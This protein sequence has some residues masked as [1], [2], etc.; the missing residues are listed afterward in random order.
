MKTIL[1]MAISK[2]GYIAGPDD[3]TPWSDAEW[4]QFQVFVK[5][6]DAVLLGKNTFKIMKADD[7]FI[8]GVRYIV[9]THDRN[10][11][12]GNY[13]KLSIE[14]KDDLPKVNRLGVIGGGDLNGCLMQMGVIDEII[15]DEEPVELGSGIKLFGSHNIKPN[16]ELLRST[17]YGESSAQRHYRVL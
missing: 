9:A 8:D 16:L 10:L 17:P 1:Y 15:L 14:S 2:D 13:E 5:S 7:D 12:T 3:E 6:C 11:D 4:E